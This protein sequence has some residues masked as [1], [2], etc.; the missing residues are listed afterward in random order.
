MNEKLEAPSR[1]LWQGLIILCCSC[2][3][4]VNAL[5][6]AEPAD[7]NYD[8]QRVP[9][10]V[11]PPLMPEAVSADIAKAHW[12]QARRSEILSLFEQHVYGKTPTDS[13]TI[14]SE[15]IEQSDNALGGIAK[16]RQLRL[17]IS[18]SATTT[19]GDSRRQIQIDVLVYTPKKAKG[20]VPAF[21]GLNF[22]GNQTVHSEPE[23]QISQQW[24]R[25]NS[26]IGIINNRATEKTRG[27]YHERWQPEMLVER[28]YGLVTAYYGDIDPDNYRHDFSDGVHPL[29]YQPGQT[30]P[31][32]NEWGAIAAW[33]WGLSKIRVALEADQLIDAKRLAV[34]GHSRLGKTALWAGAQDQEF[35]MV[36]SNNSGCGGAAL[37]RRCYGE[38]IHHML[39]P[40][41]Y[42]FCRNI[43]NYAHR[44]S[45]LPVDQHMLLALVAPRPLY[46]ASAEGDQWADP[47]GEFLAAQHASPVYKLLGTEGL[48]VDKM[49]KPNEPVAG[50]IGYHIR[51]GDHGV[52][53]YDWNQYLD[54]ADE[55]L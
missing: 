48:P 41:G 5:Y 19:N 3:F 1:N 24:M 27:V 26:S 46:V 33:A 8:E 38:R 55:H 37:F 17:T 28:G 50:R 14:S 18:P 51:V 23:I 22:Y 32:D 35:A 39:K 21:I 40:I 16:R 12:N 49:P 2:V 42:W 6:A 53:Q 34:I 4:S 54:F 7:T 9:S 20:R 45:E 30:K 11:L 44:E 15:V 10:Y 31:A 43:A 25:G 29:F 13:M 47:K 52:T 36:I